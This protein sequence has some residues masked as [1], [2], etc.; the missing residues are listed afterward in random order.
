MKKLLIFDLE[1]TLVESKSP[2][3]SEMASL[4][5]VLLCRI[6]VAVLS[7]ASW[8]EFQQQLLDPLAGN[9]N[10]EKLSLLPQCGAQ[11]YHY[12]S[13]W[14]RRDSEDFP[15]PSGIDKAHGIKMLQET[16]GIHLQEML[17][18]GDGLF[19]GGD[20]HPVTATGVVGI[21]IRDPHESKRVIEAILAC[22]CGDSHCAHPL[23]QLGVGLTF[24][25]V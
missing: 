8:L 16:L 2:L 18:I 15:S 12:R 20:D 19:P 14:E 17:F 1:G 13:G 7:G 24:L 5:S 22:L 23:T 11:Y 3:D 21:R 9:E 25:P 6:K 4:L 10:L